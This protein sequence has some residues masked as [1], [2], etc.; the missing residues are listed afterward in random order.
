MER[1]DQ[2]NDELAT[3][4]LLNAVYLVLNDIHPLHTEREDLLNALWK[5][6]SAGADE[7]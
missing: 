6:L 1:R 7:E 2:N 4:Q 3:D 5:S